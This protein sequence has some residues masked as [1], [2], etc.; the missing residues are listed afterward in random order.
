MPHSH[1]PYPAACQRWCGPGEGINR[2]HPPPHLSLM[3]STCPDSR[4]CLLTYKMRKEGRQT[5][6]IRHLSMPGTLHE[7]SQQYLHGKQNNIPISQRRKLCRGQGAGSGPTARQ[8][9]NSGLHPPML[10]SDTFVDLN[11]CMKCTDSLR[12]LLKLRALGPNPHPPSF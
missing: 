11:F 4:V 10:L 7:N 12:H 1:C 6:C 5:T 9:T 3:P 8:D 2:V